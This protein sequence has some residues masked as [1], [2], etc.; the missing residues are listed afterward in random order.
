LGAAEGKGFRQQWWGGCA[1]VRQRLPLESGASASAEKLVEVCV[2][3]EAVLK[4]FQ[5]AIIVWL[6]WKFLGRAKARLL[7]PPKHKNERQ[8]SVLTAHGLIGCWLRLALTTS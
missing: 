1:R 6:P 5:A 4:H 3:G 7:P 2:G 8:G